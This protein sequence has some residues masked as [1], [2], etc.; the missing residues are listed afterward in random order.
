MNRGLL[1]CAL[2]TV[3]FVAVATGSGLYLLGNTESTAKQSPAADKIANAD[4]HVANEGRNTPASPALETNENPRASETSGDVA[5]RNA[6]DGSKAEE[7]P[8]PAAAPN[9]VAAAKG[10]TERRQLL[11][12]LGA[13]TASHC[14]QTYL[15]IGLIADGK[16]NGTYT[17]KDAYKL[18][19]SVLALVSSVDR[20]LAA[21]DRIDLEKED[22]ASL[23]QMRTL[24][25]LLRKQAKDL[26]A[27]WDTGKEEDAARYESVRKDSWAAL[28]RLTGVGR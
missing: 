6:D 20:K 21:L 22:C 23:E 4:D 19:D 15:N 10:A 9:Q 7:T 5:K 17:E 1:M 16:A 13:L 18:L 27:F 3:A 12:V 26:Q 14:Y 24:S 25:I 2:L 11:E 28:S 8:K